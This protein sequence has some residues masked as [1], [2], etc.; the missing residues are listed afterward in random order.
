MHFKL[1]F[2]LNQDALACKQTPA[3]A[4]YVSV[5]SEVVCINQ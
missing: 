1:F 5:N 2:F 3:Q 4:S